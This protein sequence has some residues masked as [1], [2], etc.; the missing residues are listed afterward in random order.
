MGYA[1]FDEPEP[2]ELHLSKILLFTDKNALG[3]FW[4][5]EKL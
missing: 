1:V 2:P 4:K 5:R 3:I